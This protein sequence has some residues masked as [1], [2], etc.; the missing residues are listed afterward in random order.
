MKFLRSLN[1]K[2]DLQLDR[3]IGW[4][5]LQE[6]AIKWAAIA[7]PILVA[8]LILDYGFWQVSSGLA[9]RGDRIE[10]AIASSKQRAST[11]S[12]AIESSV[13]A[14]GPVDAPANKDEGANALTTSIA[15]IFKANNTN[16]GLGLREQ[17]IGSRELEG[18]VG[19]RIEKVVAEIR[20][21]ATPDTV[22]AI[23]AQLEAAPEIDSI[24]DLKLNYQPQTR[25]VAVQ[26]SAEAWTLA[27][28]G[29]A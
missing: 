7:I 11:I 16:F 25:R 6:R 17:R 22:S 28:G 13:R 4:Y 14:F 29:D 10:S 5:C 26:L 23:I 2:F 3:A 18:A 27:R 8:Y 21:E 15:A 19:S 9:A 12:G 24:S 1:S 20:F